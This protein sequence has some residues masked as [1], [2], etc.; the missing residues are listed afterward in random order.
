KKVKFEKTCM[1]DLKKHGIA[2]KFVNKKPG[3][4]WIKTVK[5][6]REKYN[7]FKP[8]IVHTHLESV[9]FHICRALAKYD[10]PII[11]TIHSS[12]IKYPFIQKHYISKKTNMYV[13]ISEK[14]RENIHNQIDIQYGNICLMYNG[15]EVE[16]FKI[17]DRNVYEPVNKIISVGRL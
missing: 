3:R 13:A 2:V 8:D 10:V 9:T 15:I 1:D 4:D 7:L 11:Q 16:K 17:I 5:I 6:L 14:V 12:V